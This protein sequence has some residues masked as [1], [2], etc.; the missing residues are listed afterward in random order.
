MVILFD[1]D[2]TLL[3]SERVAREAR[4]FGFQTVLGRQVKPEEEAFFLGKPVK[5]VLAEWFPE[6]AEE[7]SS[8]IRARYTEL[9][10][11]VQPY[12]GV[13]NMLE[14]LKTEGFTMGIVSSKRN[15]N[16][17]REL[18]ATGLAPFFEIIVGQDDTVKHKPDPEP[19]LLALNKLQASP[20]HCTYIGDQPTDIAAAQSAG[21]RHIA[22][23]WGDGEEKHF[24][25]GHQTVI[26]R[27]PHEIL[28]LVC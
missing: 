21:I 23:T 17:E 2:G 3:D 18:L 22:A 4:N 27:T 14:N 6:K 11:L 19:L 28:A 20:A 8:V 15:N 16:I 7:L 1:L 9:S 13:T 26:A 24:L 10:P 5:K 25:E 12:S